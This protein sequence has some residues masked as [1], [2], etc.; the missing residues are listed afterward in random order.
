MSAGESGAKRRVAVV[1]TA[2]SDYGI[3]RPLLRAIDE[4]P[5]LDLQ[6]IVAASH[7][8]SRFGY[9]ISEIEADGFRPV[10]RIHAPLDGD[11]AAAVGQVMGLL[12]AGAAAAYQ[13]L[14]PDIVVALGDR[15]EMHAAVAAAVPFLIP[16][17]H[18]AGGA[19]R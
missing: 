9:T 14:R 3:Y 8:D 5:R 2:R 15:Y 17:A 7:L 1:T 19:I 6:L 12:S 10:A 4:D 11:G 18:V 16:I 13:K